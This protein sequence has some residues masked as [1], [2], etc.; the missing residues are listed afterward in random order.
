MLGPLLIQFP[1]SFRF[2]RTN[3]DWLL[4]IGERLRDY[5]RVILCVSF[6]LRGMRVSF[7]CGVN[8]TTRRRQ[9]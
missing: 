8:D 9:S 3:A 5:Q 4:R 7:I 6:P 2:D 1:W